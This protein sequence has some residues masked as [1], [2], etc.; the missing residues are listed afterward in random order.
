[1]RIIHHSL[2]L[3]KKGPPWGRTAL[4]RFLFERNDQRLILTEVADQ[5]QARLR[6]SIKLDIAI[7][8]TKTEIK[9]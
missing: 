9:M 3:T 6:M 1:M 4:I 8:T 2:Q 5:P 7:A